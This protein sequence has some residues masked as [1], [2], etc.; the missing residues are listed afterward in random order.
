MVTGVALAKIYV[1]H[2]PPD[3]KIYALYSNNITIDC[4]LL[5]GDFDISNYQSNCLIYVH[6]ARGIDYMDS[7]PCAQMNRLLHGKYIC[8][9]EH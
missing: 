3:Y 4:V 9:N 2:V 8:I 1:K 5:L 7:T 6:V